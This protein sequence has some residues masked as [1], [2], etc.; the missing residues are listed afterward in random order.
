MPHP[1]P[2]SRR[3][4]WPVALMG[5]LV[6]L[7]LTAPAAAAH[8]ELVSSSPAD[9]AILQT[10]PTTVVL[11][12]NEAA[13]ALGTR[14]IVT[15]PAGEVQTGKPRLV[16]RTVAQNLQPGSPAGRYTV[17]W[18]VVSDDGHPVSGSFVFTVAADAPTPAATITPSAQH[19]PSAT[20][21]DAPP[22]PAT[23]PPGT[24]VSGSPV[25]GGVWAAAALGVLVVAA[26]FWSI[27]HRRRS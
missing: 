13:V 20:A 27:A 15:G 22:T 16:E 8:T 6:A 7:A 5:A 19:S 24:T 26:V 12:L 11:T 9:G 3:R 23:P 4:R 2:L 21:V 17:R 14:V 18:R 10:A 25:S 1:V